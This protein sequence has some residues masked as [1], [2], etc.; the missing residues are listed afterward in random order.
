MTT[1]EEINCRCCID[2]QYYVGRQYHKQLMKVFW[3]LSKYLLRSLNITDYR[4]LEDEIVK[5]ENIYESE[6]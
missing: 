4:N 1:D 5:L 2:C 3:R 6:E